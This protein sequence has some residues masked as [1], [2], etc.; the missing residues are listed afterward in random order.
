[1]AIRFFQN[2]LGQ[3]IIVGI[4]LN[5]I[6]PP[7]TMPNNS[8][9]MWRGIRKSL[10]GRLLNTKPMETCSK[11]KETGNGAADQRW[12]TGQQRSTYNWL[13]LHFKQNFL[14]VWV[15][16]QRAIVNVWLVWF[17]TLQSLQE[18][19]NVWGG[20]AEM[21][22][23]NLLTGAN[24]EPQTLQNDVCIKWCISR[25]LFQC[26]SLYWGKTLWA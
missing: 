6:K 22:G 12:K 3:K 21:G 10:W 9:S 19:E 11:L 13:I 17:S 1:M 20:L 8:K 5:W 4:Y 24:C 14:F 7:L 15:F 16:N 2:F 18:N 26:K 23:S 25:L